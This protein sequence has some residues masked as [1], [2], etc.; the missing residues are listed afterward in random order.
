MKYKYKLK[1]R[2]TLSN[3]SKKRRLKSEGNP[4][5]TQDSTKPRGRNSRNRRREVC[6]T[7][8]TTTTTNQPKCATC[9]ARVCHNLLSEN[10]HE[11][12]LSKDNIPPRGGST[13]ATSP[14]A[15]GLD[16]TLTRFLACDDRN[17]NPF[18][19]WDLMRVEHQQP[20]DKSET[21]DFR[22]AQMS[23]NELSPMQYSVEPG[24]EC[25]T[26]TDL[27]GAIK[28]IELSHIGHQ[29]S[30]NTNSEGNQ[31]ND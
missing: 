4:N 3:R 2:C 20:L 6:T 30:T 11:L 21:Y 27:E 13:E 18:S 14:R 31:A 10:L 17:V 5:M 12:S 25:F 22:I 23:E 15:S 19:E 24:H 28:P 1:S 26:S 8:T 9:P 29:F 16:Y 7:T